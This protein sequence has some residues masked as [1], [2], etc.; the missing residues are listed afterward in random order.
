MPA[1]SPSLVL[2]LGSVTPPGRLHR[3]VAAAEERARA[4]RPDLDTTVFDLG[5]LQ[6]AYA[7]GTPPADLGDDTAHVV[8]AVAAADAVLLAT[9][10]YRG[11]LTG[12]LKNLLDHLPVTALRGTP[13]GIAA[14]GAS[15][16]HFLGAD[17][18]L[19]DILTFFGA[20]VPPT[21]AYLTSKDFADGLPSED[22]LARLDAVV[23]AV[24]ALA[25]RLG[26]APLGP[27]PIGAG[28]G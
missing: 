18:H 4:A 13:V 10:V 23:D 25:D 24:L 16:H 26:G 3:A 14:M 17:R 21:S 15:D 9:P 28:R 5:A 19:R 11:S 7:D 1:S 22:A 2:V 12:A 6:I 20:V 8:D 27:P